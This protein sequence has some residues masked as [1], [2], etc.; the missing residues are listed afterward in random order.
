MGICASKE[1]VVDSPTET[2]TI[3]E[4]EDEN[5]FPDF[6]DPSVRVTTTTPHS[7]AAIDSD[8]TDSLE[9]EVALV[10]NSSPSNTNVPTR[11]TQVADESE[12]NVKPEIF[13]QDVESEPPPI[14]EMKAQSTPQPEDNSSSASLRDEKRSN[15]KHD[16][17][18]SEK[19]KQIF[20]ETQRAQKA[21]AKAEADA[22]EKAKIEAMD[23]EERE[24]YLAEKAAAELHEKRK[25]KMLAKTM[26][27]YGGTTAKGILKN[28]RGRKKKT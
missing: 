8:K 25:T 5:D 24:A 9:N 22:Q 2:M 6:I 4:C 20:L 7:S 10:Q 27:G 26:K 3:I 17:N 28:K 18:T 15:D 16:Q 12:G 13:P 11:S 19:R 23:V 14:P 1:S 21:E